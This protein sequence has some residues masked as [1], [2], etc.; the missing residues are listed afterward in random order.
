MTVSEE[1]A[2]SLLLW[3]V[4]KFFLRTLLLNS[5]PRLMM[6]GF[7]YMQ[8]ILINNT[9]RYV[10]EPSA[11]ESNHQTTGYYLVLTAF[12]IYVGMGVCNAGPN[13]LFPL[14]DW[15]YRYH[16]ASTTKPTI[17]L[18]YNRVVSSLG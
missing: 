16:S 11:E 4:F 9:I 13:H 3:V 6:I 5:I 1:N 12:V 15:Y 17:A 18:K 2:G 7:R 10:T 8:P 14:T